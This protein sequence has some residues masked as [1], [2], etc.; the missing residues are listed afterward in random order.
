V[1]IVFD[2]KHLA[3]NGKPAPNIHGWRAAHEM[4]AR[5]AAHVAHL[6][7]PETETRSMSYFARKKGP[8]SLHCEPLARKL[9][10]Y[11]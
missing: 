2:I 9:H 7:T 5:Q 1:P 8:V 3:R 6:S 10:T 11:S 4:P